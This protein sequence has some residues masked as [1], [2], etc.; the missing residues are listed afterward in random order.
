MA[1]V[2]KVRLTPKQ[3]R[4]CEEYLIDLNATQAAI[5]AGYSKKTA[6]EQG[7]RLLVNVSISHYISELKATLRED[8]KVTAQMVID[9]LVKIG[10]ANIQD[11]INGGNSVLELKGLDKNKTAAV[12]GIKTTINENTGSI[13]TDLRFHNKVAALDLL[14]KHFGIFERDND[15]RKPEVPTAMQITIVVPKEVDE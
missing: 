5:R 8:N 4:F 13:T 14:G 7:A 9:E 2:G 3:Q 12:A 1:E 10:L 11:F 15:Q 6:N